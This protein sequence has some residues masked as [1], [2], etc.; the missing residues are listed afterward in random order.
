[1]RG[2]RRI[3]RLLSEF[4]AGVVEELG[5]ED[6]ITAAQSV[7]IEA[8]LR[9]YGVILLA[10]LYVGKVG[11]FREDKAAEGVLE[12]QPVLGQSFLAY[13]N[14]IRLNLAALFPGG[15]SQRIEEGLTLA[16]VLKENAERKE[17]EA[18]DDDQGSGQ[19]SAS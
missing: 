3:E 10:D 7:L 19:G 15:L 13:T 8:T 1:M 16:A 2:K 6:R 5:G 17:K 11:I 18:T 9:G 4:R 12:L 14:N